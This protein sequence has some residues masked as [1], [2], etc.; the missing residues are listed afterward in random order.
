MERADA[1]AEVEEEDL[2]PWLVTA[3][4]RGAPP[5]SSELGHILRAYRQVHGLSQATLAERLLLTQ[6]HLSKIES[7]RRPV[8]DVDQLRWIADRLGLPH[9]RLGLLPD[10]STEGM[11]PTELVA[12]LGPVGES[13]RAWCHVRRKLNQQRHRLSR[14]AAQL[15]PE[16]LRVE[17]TL[18]LAA[19]NWLPAFPLEL[20]SITTAWQ[21]SAPPPRFRGADAEAR[22]VPV[23]AAVPL[24]DGTK[25][26][27]RYSRAMRDLA[28]PKLFDNRSCYRPVAVETEPD[29][30]HMDF[31]YTSYF[32]A[33]DVAEALAHEFAAAWLAD[34]SRP[35]S[36]EDLPLR[37]AVG[38]P[39]DPSGRP[40]C[41]SIN[42]LTLRGDPSGAASFLLHKRNPGAVATGGVYHVL[43]C[44]VFQ[45]S[46]VSP[47][48]QANDLNPWR[49]IMREFSEEL[50]GT[51]EHDGNDS[52]PI[53]YTA[54]E[55]FRSLNL[56]RTEGRIRAYCLGMVLEPLTL[57][58][59]LQTVVV[60]DADT[61][62]EIFGNLVSSN[63]E[64]QLLAVGPG[65]AAEGIPFTAD[66]LQ[67]LA[68]AP[69]APVAASLLRLAWR[70]RSTL[71]GK[72]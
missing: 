70:H 25:R 37:A 48:D 23:D 56:A 5:A 39:L 43:P 24:V 32:E 47:W 69:L 10:H 29:R 20:D 46:S 31:A 34:R 27:D 14:L 42:T 4:A 66:N 9:E 67:R 38:D 71:L 30:W 33:L 61:F 64:G 40:M 45:P 22:G 18:A 58:G 55:P 50:L 36:I 1:V 41:L 7:G 16:R 65:S 68:D 49:N 6:P 57:W 51:P 21:T 2:V 63:E 72:R 59:E 3:E 13:Q 28:R 17:G 19:P 53:D 8:H 12:A 44:G 60:F 62:D 26:Y 54:L 11:P 52:A 35:V 15:Y